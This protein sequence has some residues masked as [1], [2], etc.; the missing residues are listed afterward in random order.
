MDISKKSQEL[1]LDFEPS[2]PALLAPSF[3][4]ASF[5]SKGSKFPI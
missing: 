3:A 5:V 4:N 1:D 2:D